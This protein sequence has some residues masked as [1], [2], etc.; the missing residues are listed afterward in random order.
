MTELAERYGVG[1]STIGGW[2]RAGKVRRID[3][4]GH[5]LI[6]EEDVER[7]AERVK[8]AA[9]E[10]QASSRPACA[11]PT[12][13]RAAHTAGRGYCLKH[14]E[15]LHIIRPLVPREKA[16][17]ALQQQLDRG[18]SPC[19]LAKAAGVSYSTLYKFMAGPDSSWGADGM[20][21]STYEAI[22]NAP[23]R[24][25]YTPAW[26][27]ARRVQS[28]RAAGH[29]VQ[30]IMDGARVSQDVLTRLS[31]QKVERI[32]TEVHD[33][34]VDYYRQHEAKPVRPVEPRIAKRRWPLPMEW[35]DIDDPREHRGLIT[36]QQARDLVRMTPTIVSAA[37]WLADYYGTRDRASTEIGLS[38]NVIST[39]LRGDHP[40]STR[41][42]AHRVTY[43]ASRL[44]WTPHRREEAA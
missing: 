33:R 8:L 27:A 5:G 12:C 25:T 6:N 40:T 2:V 36:R 9:Q 19:S 29:S 18:H 24:T 1:T 11:R 31:F 26:H 43:M 20:K 39:I 13:S 34:I 28:L 14:A 37:Q 41:E 10:R 3:T 42:V 15:V 38:H 7:H 30:E 44:G 16:L 22:L 32:R 17:A 21:Q 35:W 23:L 4:Y